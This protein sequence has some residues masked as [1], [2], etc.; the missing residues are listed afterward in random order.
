MK[1]VKTYGRTAKTAAA[2]IRA[3]EQRGAVSTARVQ[4]VVRRILADVRKS[5]DKALSK[6]AA[7]F[8]GLANNQ[9]LLVTREEMQA[10]WQ[11]TAPELQAAMM[12]AR[13]NIL[14]FAEAQLPKEW[15]F[16]ATDGVKTG[17][18]VRSLGSV[19]CYVPGGR[20]PLP[21]PHS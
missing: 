4:P 15:S 21:P 6:Y 9:P 14:A 2:L 16:T 19:G 13:A 18:I 5:G 20:Y 3:I 1:L 12:T 8:D 7:K 10:A 17:Q 11:S